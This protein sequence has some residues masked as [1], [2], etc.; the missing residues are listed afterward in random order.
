MNSRQESQRVSKRGFKTAC[1]LTMAWVTVLG[2]SSGDDNKP[3]PV[4][5]TAGRGTAACHEWQESFC[6]HLTNC[7][8]T[9]MAKCATQVQTLTCAS[10][11]TAANCATA[12]EAATCPGIPSGCNSN[13]IADRTW[14]SAACTTYLTALCTHDA[15]CGSSVTVADCVPKLQTS[16]NCAQAIGVK[17]NYEDCLSRIN[18]AACSDAIASE[19]KSLIY[20]A[21]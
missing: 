11:E 1:C 19:C 9:E 8:A 15:N 17:L 10:D 13:D 14:A 16:S 6:T 18:A 4:D 3:T 21:S 20:V 12:I 7:G 2:C 5:W